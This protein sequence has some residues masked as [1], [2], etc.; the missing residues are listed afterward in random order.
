MKTS[1]EDAEAWELGRAREAPTAST[2]THGHCDDHGQQSKT[3]PQSTLED[4]WPASWKVALIIIAM[5]VLFIGGVLIGY[6]L[7]PNTLMTPPEESNSDSEKVNIYAK[8][9]SDQSPS[10]EALLQ[11]HKQLLPL[12]SKH[13]PDN[14]IK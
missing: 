9:C 2:S 7:K 6:F 3:T 10:P 5:C 1:D 12:I 4:S 14:F 11:V 13:N 8:M